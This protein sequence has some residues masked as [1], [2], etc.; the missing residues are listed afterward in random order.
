MSAATLRQATAKRWRESPKGQAYNRAYQVV[1]RV[2][3]KHKWREY[4][5]RWREKNPDKYKESQL[6]GCRTYRRKNAEKLRLKT[7]AYHRQRQA[8]DRENNKL[9][10]KKNPHKIQ[11]YNAR[12]RARKLGAKGRHTTK[13]W[14]ARVAVFLWCCRYCGMKLTTKTLTQDHQV[15]LSRGGANWPSNLVPAC[16]HCNSNKRTRRLPELINVIRTV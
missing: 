14:L 8:A 5:D 7:R 2:R 12:R 11:E 4:R 6:D 10:L 15:P 1:Y 16:A 3:N 13:Q 9:W